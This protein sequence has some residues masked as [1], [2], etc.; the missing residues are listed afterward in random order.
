MS[1]HFC[2]FK[3]DSNENW[4][5]LSG[6]TSQ[7]ACVAKM[8][9]LS[10]EN[11]SPRKLKAWSPSPR[12][13][14]CLSLNFLRRVLP[15]LLRSYGWTIPG[16]YSSQAIRPIALRMVMELA[17][18]LPEVPISGIGGIHEG[19]DALQFMLLGASSVQV[20]T[21]VMLKGY[22]MVSELKE[23]LAAF[24][25]DHEFSSVR[26]FIGVSLPYFTT[27]ADLVKRMVSE[28]AQAAVPSRDD[29]WAATKRLADLAGEL[30]TGKVAL[31]HKS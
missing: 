6:S 22:E 15:G 12:Q 5:F 14:L 13:L 4:G 3:K 24:M 23:S 17:R 31:S 21:G 10:W 18:T 26:D 8:R 25:R 30:T 16:G 2:Q 11:S 28:R 1:R 20:C 19:K 27:H 7:I 29:D 9:F